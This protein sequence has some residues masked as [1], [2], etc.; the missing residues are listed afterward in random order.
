MLPSLESTAESFIF[1]SV[2]FATNDEEEEEEMRNACQA[3]VSHP[4]TTVL[5]NRLRDA[6]S[7]DPDWLDRQQRAQQ[8]LA[9]RGSIPLSCSFF[10]R[11]GKHYIETMTVAERAAAVLQG[12]AT[13]ESHRL[14]RKKRKTTEALPPSPSFSSGQVAS[15]MFYACRVPGRVVDTMRTYYHSVPVF[16]GEASLP[17]AIV[18]TRGQFYKVPLYDAQRNVLSHRILKTCIQQITEY[19]DQHCQERN[20][21][22]PPE[23]GWLTKQD[24]DLW[25]TDHAFLRELGFEEALE[26]IYSSAMLLALETE[27]LNDV[28]R[29]LKIFRGNRNRDMARRL[30]LGG[31]DRWHDKTSQFVLFDKGNLGYIGEASSLTMAEARLYC[32]HLH[33]LR[34]DDTDN[35]PPATNYLAD[36]PTLVTPVFHETFRKLP[37]IDQDR[38]RERVRI[39]RE[40][41]IHSTRDH[42]VAVLDVD[43]HGEH[44]LKRMQIPIPAYL[45]IA[46]EL[47]ASRYFPEQ[48]SVCEIVDRESS[49]GYDI[50]RPVSPHSR[51][52]CNAM[53]KYPQSNQALILLRRALASYTEYRDNVKRG[54]GVD[55]HFDGLQRCIEEGDEIPELFA[56]SVF[57]KSKA[58]KIVIATQSHM[59][60]GVGSFPIESRYD[61]WFSIGCDMYH[62]RLSI[63]ITSKTTMH[64]VHKFSRLLGLSINDMILL[65]LHPV[66][67][68]PR[69]RKKIVKHKFDYTRK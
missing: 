58:W 16:H 52:F 61:G 28:D 47:A 40:T 46:V 42:D 14:F 50:V 9:Q 68:W 62:Q 63:T 12:V 25:Y 1:S 22:S 7:N 34:Y 49:F 19:H 11:I 30:Y 60:P 53:K 23:L 37:A 35:K 27:P 45:P 31:P 43:T 66:H 44:I 36:A 56:N 4:T 17:H 6:I 39:A 8:T 18:V 33:N 26:T 15:H 2:A 24:R 57:Q 10:F 69:G 54:Q 48:A 64:D 32:M 20:D 65:I 3:F 38:L 51:D 29:K 41:F 5:Q 59:M 21:P 55:R 13:M 67:F